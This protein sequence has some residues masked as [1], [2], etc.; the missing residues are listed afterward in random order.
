[1][2]R[3]FLNSYAHFC[4]TES[5]RHSHTK[6][7]NRD[8]VYCTITPSP[9]VLEPMLLVREHG[10]NENFRPSSR[11]PFPSST[12]RAVSLCCENEIPRTK[13]QA[14]GTLPPT[15]LGLKSDKGK[16]NKENCILL[17][18]CPEGIRRGFKEHILKKRTGS[19]ITTLRILYPSLFQKKKTKNKNIQKYK[20]NT[21]INKCILTGMRY[22]VEY[23]D[24]L[25]VKI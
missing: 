7:R 14:R 13:K 10:T 18:P 24:P 22:V 11:S 23:V 2:P 1:M 5:S 3:P 8:E 19:L 9:A 12:S 20:N 16:F 17:L 21:D 15:Q 4:R 6:Q 25:T